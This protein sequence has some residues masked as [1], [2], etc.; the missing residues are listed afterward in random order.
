[1]VAGRPVWIF[2]RAM[3]DD[4]RKA[5]RR[6]LDRRAPEAAEPE[7]AAEP[8]PGQALVPVPSPEPEEADGQPRQAGTR[9]GGFAGFAA[10]ML[11]QGGQKRGLRGGP[12]TLDRARSTYLGAEWSGPADRRPRP[13][14]ITKTEI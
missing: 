8:P 4:R 9:R 11:G 2:S 7:A 1:M 5:E 14:R 13:G 6:T 3:T 12:E 10:Q